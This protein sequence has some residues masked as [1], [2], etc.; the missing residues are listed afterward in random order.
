MISQSAE[1][2]FV[3]APGAG[4]L[5]SAVEI[6]KHLV[7]RDS[8]LSVTVLIITFPVASNVRSPTKFFVS[9]SATSVSERIKFVDLPESPI[10]GADLTIVSFLSSFFEKKKP[11]VR[12]AVRKLV[13]S[14]S[15]SPDSPRLAGF[16]V[17]MFCTTMIDV[18]DEFGVPSYVFYTSGAGCISLVSHMLTLIDEHNMDSTDFKDKPDSELLVPGFTNPVP[19]KVLPGVL[20]DKV[21]APLFL[22]HYRRIRSSKGILVNSFME[23]ESNV[24]LSLSHS[25]LPPIYPVGPVLNLN[26]G[27]SDKKTENIVAW[28]DKQPPSSVVFLCFGSMGSFG[29]EQAKEIALALERSGIRFLWS[30]RKPPQRGKVPVPSDYTDLNEAL[31]EG[32]L[33]RT[34][35]IGKVIGWAPQVAILAHPAVAGFV[36]HCGW[37]STLESLWFGVPV[38]TW[39]MYA[40]QQF[41]AFQLVREL[42]LAVEIKMD[43]RKE[44]GND[45][46][47]VI[48]RAE[49]IERGIKSVMEHDSDIRKRVQEMTDKSRKSMLN[50][51]SSY[52][53]LGRFIDDVM[54]SMH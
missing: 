5:V 35:E 37:N 53:S 17:D 11:L 19:A 9:S 38:A 42:G 48:L 54:Q 24:I 22:N 2:I 33:D 47:A 30:L 4:H 40:E 3:P 32:F 31:P 21:A 46:E 15:G 44:L 51:G 18:A 16:V 12:D 50:G 28:L 41:N 43:Y 52:S 8:R 20:F 23:L 26:P 13:D 1:L 36:S 45:V 7:A 14:N 10:D 25:E 39:P 34:A 27:G 29:E 49:E 6:A